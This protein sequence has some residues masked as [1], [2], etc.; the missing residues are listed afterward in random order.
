MPRLDTGQLLVR[1]NTEASLAPRVTRQQNGR[2]TARVAPGLI[3]WL[4]TGAARRGTPTSMDARDG[5]VSHSA[6]EPPLRIQHARQDLVEPAG[7]PRTVDETG[8]TVKM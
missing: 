1:P 6:G 7:A 4:R 3:G 2:S 8:M 5:D